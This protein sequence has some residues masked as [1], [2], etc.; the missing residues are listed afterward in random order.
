MGF[1]VLN[2]TNFQMDLGFIQWWYRISLQQ[3]ETERKLHGIH[4]KMNGVIM[5]Y[6]SRHVNYATGTTRPFVQYGGCK[7]YP[8]A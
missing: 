1:R 8:R 7:K 2:F 5:K 3:I 6:F 4:A